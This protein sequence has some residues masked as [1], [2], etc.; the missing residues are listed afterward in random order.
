MMLNRD[1][2]QTRDFLAG[3]FWSELPESTARRRLSNALWRIRKTVDEALGGSPLLVAT[4]GEIRVNPDQELR[5][6]VEIFQRRL[7]ALERRRQADRHSVTVEE[8][9]EAVDPYKGDLLEGYYEDWIIGPRQD[10]LSRYLDALTQM[11]ALY[12]RSGDYEGALRPARLRIDAEHFSDEWQRDVIRLYALNGMP[13]AA[14]QHF[15]R[16][17]ADMEEGD[18]PSREMLALVERIRDDA[19][20]LFEAEEVVEDEPGT[21]FTGRAR[22]RALLLGRVNELLDGGG[23]LVLVEGEAGVG[24]TRLMEEMVAGARWRDVRVLT[25]PHA[26]STQLKPFGGLR[27]ALQSAIRGLNGERLATQLASV[28]LRQAAGVL[29]ELSQY[30]DKSDSQALRPQEEPWRTTEALALVLLSLAHA[31]PTVLV[32]E[33]VQWCDDDTLRVLKQVGDRLAD[34]GLL[35][36]L[37]YQRHVA[38]RSSMLWRTLGDLEARASSTRL[39]LGPMELD[40]IRAL[41]AAEMGHGRVSEPVIG[42]LATLSGGNPYVVL[43]LLR[44]G[45]DALEEDLTRR[46]SDMAGSGSVLPWLQQVLLERVDAAPDDMRRV[47]DAAAVIGAP[48][49]SRLVAQVAGLEPFEAISA[50][51]SAVN[52]G[53]LAEDEAGRVE[54]AQEQVRVLL[55]DRLDPPTR[56]R[57]HG[58]TV[59]ALVGEEG[60]GVEQLAYHA[61]LASQWHRAHQYGSLA[62]ESALELNAFETAA[63]HFTMADAAAQRIG[64]ADAD[65]VH[66]LLALERVLDVLGRRDAQ[67]AL[68]D[69]LDGLDPERRTTT[70]VAQRRAWLLANTD[71]RDE[72]IE[73]ASAAVGQAREHGHGIEELLTVIGV[74]RSWSGDLAGAIGPLEEALEA[75]E[76]VGKSPVEAQMMLGRV[77]IDLDRVDEAREHLEAANLRAKQDND[78]RAQ[79]EALGHLAALHTSQHNDLQ[80][81]SSFQEALRLAVDIGYRHGE[82]LNLVN[83]VA[84]Y[85]MQGRGGKALTLVDRAEEV[86]HSLGN[87][88]GVAYAKNNGASIRHW[89]LGAD[90]DAAADAQD[91]AVYFRSVNDAG[92]E[93]TCLTTLASIDF[94]AGRRR[95]AKRRLE[96]ARRQC[97]LAHDPSQLVEIHCLE[98]RVDLDL[99]LLDDASAAIDAADALRLEHHLETFAS[100]IHVTGARIKLA[101]GA[102]EDAAALVEEAIAANRPG[103]HLSYLVAWW[104]AGLLEQL[105]ESRGA[106]EQTLLAHELLSRNLEELP[107]NQIDRA[108]SSVAEHQAI[109]VARERF[110]A[111]RIEVRLPAADTPTGRP[112]ETTDYVSVVLTISHPSDWEW[113]NPA[114]RRQRRIHRLIQQA[115][116]QNARA[117]VTDLAEILGVSA[118]TIKR[119]LAEM[120]DESHVEGQDDDFF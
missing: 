111:E 31:Q 98:A 42:Q 120:R 108:W 4:Q 117:R 39:A 6:D 24:K 113:G 54:F 43:E 69:R 21:P 25:A 11:V 23:G 51:S 101:S 60:I 64:L 95:L 40:E 74:T 53:F 85:A 66:D 56:T 73:L 34:S 16:Y 110:L 36:C 32:L 13:S 106:E 118:R 78:A 18:E 84:F 49:M 107:A 70:E 115:S 81:E 93:A 119:D 92:T 9:A 41:V 105:G 33:D 103:S 72:A 22:E 14:I 35:V 7:D 68:L 2:P 91:A 86:F 19:D 48:T 109:A 102:T 1:R 20:K 76:T 112:L 65:R 99:G 71:R 87:G 12:S 38:Q 97:A 3:R 89:L 5:I 10:L 37:T 77:L 15:E 30:V 88:R 75:F 67:L 63:E 44:S 61:G 94:R 96:A 55:Y 27:V 100:T 58:L 29:P 83:L 45:S 46:E 82:G 116:E 79:V 80:A 52:A 62:A 114:A 8:L 104:C 26:A 28:W 17:T 47:L 90:E 59:D 50:L 57:L